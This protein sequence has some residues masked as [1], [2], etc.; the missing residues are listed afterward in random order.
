[1]KKLNTKHVKYAGVAVL[2]LILLPLLP[3]IIGSY[4]GYRVYKNSPNKK[5]GLGLASLAIVISLFL[6]GAFVQAFPSS[7][8]NKPSPTPTVEITATKAP[9][10]TPEDTKYPEQTKTPEPTQIPESNNRVKAKV[11]KVVDGDTMDFSVD[12]KTVRIRV[13]GIDTPE[14]VDPRKSVE[15]FGLEASKQAK[16]YLETG[17]EVELES[18]PT[19]G[20]LDKYNRLLR[21]VWTDDG[22]V[23]F[24]KVMISLGYAFEYTYNT[25]YKY[26]SIYKAAQKEA[27]ANNAG[28][29]ADGAC[30]ITPVPTIK[31]VTNIVSD[32]YTGSYSCTGPDLD[33]S[34]FSTHSQAQAFFDGC[35]FTTTNDPMKLD[36]VGIGDGV[37]CESLP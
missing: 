19:Q 25:P 7:N 29:W 11:V 6:T 1:M 3:L 2:C 10:T 32:T 28:L 34:D 15:C 4:I 26:Q 9:E 8:T 35:G 23:D 20:E 16:Y 5:K 12:G 13:I 18:D 21:Y 31:P 14:T 37:A 24:G 17:M 27:E 22:N 33:C 30:A 36:S